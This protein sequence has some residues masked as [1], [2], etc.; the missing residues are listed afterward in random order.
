MYWICLKFVENVQY[1]S[2]QSIFYIFCAVIM[3]IWIKNTCPFLIKL[4]QHS[5]QRRSVEWY[6]DNS[7]LYRTVWNKQTLEEISLSHPPPVQGIEAATPP[8]LPR[9]FKTIR[10][11]RR[12]KKQKKRE[13]LKLRQ[14]KN[15]RRILFPFFLLLVIAQ[16]KQCNTPQLE[17]LR[18][19]EKQF[20][21][22]KK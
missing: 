21:P 22:I 12:K 8:I 10:C 15:F 9:L 19:V 4:S 2:Q 13:L 7:E 16:Q 5:H 6:N 18:A 17:S 14:T 11:R 20:K 3:T 1:L